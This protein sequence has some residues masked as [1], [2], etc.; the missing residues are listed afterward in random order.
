MVLSDS[1]TSD[2][3]VNSGYGTEKSYFSHLGDILMH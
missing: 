1:Y 2:V 3:M